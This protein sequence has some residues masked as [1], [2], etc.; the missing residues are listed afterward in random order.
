V[1]GGSAAVSKHEVQK[2]AQHES[3]AQLAAMQQQQ[4]QLERDRQIQLA[5]DEARE[6]RE[7]EEEKRRREEDERERRAEA[8]LYSSI[9]RGNIPQ[10]VS[11]QPVVGA[12]PM[13]HPPGISSS[14][15]METSN[16][17][18]IRFCTACGQKCE[19]QHKFCAFCG[20]KFA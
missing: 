18:G 3:Q 10:P 7:R 6:R 16:L 1:L 2:Q 17:A 20:A 12:A 4:A 9:G 11:F 19:M 15:G 5:A 14:S 8:V 13:A